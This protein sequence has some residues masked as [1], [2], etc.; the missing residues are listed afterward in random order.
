MT[1]AVFIL[2]VK[3]PYLPMWRRLRLCR[4]FLSLAFGLVGLSCLKTV[5][6][7]LPTSHEVIQT[8][9]LISGGF[10]AL[11]F[12]C[13]GLT[14]VAPRA[15]SKRFVLPIVMML[16]INAASMI[17]TLV[18]APEYFFVA[19]VVSLLIYVAL[20]VYYQVEFFKH[21]NH[22]VAVTDEATDEYSVY[23]YRWIKGFYISVTVLGLS[24]CCVVFAPVAV[25]DVWMLIAALFYAYVVL[26]FVNYCSRNALVVNKVYNQDETNVVSIVACDENDQ[27][28]IFEQRLNQWVM[29]KNFVRNDIMSC[30][31]AAQLGVSVE[32]FRAYFKEHLNTD[33]RQWRMKQRI[34]YACEI[35]AQHPTYAYSMVAQQ[36]GI[37]DRSNFTKAFL[38]IKGITPKEFLDQHQY[39]GNE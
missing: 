10:Q 35:L 16:L 18:L 9:T 4:V 27:L 31:I 22:L 17:S 3:I 13:T 21:Y 29:D 6:F 24:V 23:S 7:R 14:F 5:L 28:E 37:N 25:Y 34:D 8:S 19:L 39:C 26:C 12:C 38:K 32:E 11:M 20:I 36:V 30:E 33:F 2:L 1:S 15:V